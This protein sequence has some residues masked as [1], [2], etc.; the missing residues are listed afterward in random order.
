MSGAVE[1]SFHEQVGGALSGT[2]DATERLET[3]SLPEPDPVGIGEV[4]VNSHTAPS[5]NFPGPFGQTRHR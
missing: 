3:D 1:T 5:V 4:R 2:G